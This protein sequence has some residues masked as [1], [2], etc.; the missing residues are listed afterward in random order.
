MA[1]C[2]HGEAWVRGRCDAMCLWDVA[3]AAIRPFCSEGS[4][5]EKGEW[6]G[7]WGVYGGGL[8]GGEGGSGEGVDPH[9]SRDWAIVVKVVESDAAFA[10]AAQSAPEDGP[11]AIEVLRHYAGVRDDNGD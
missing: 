1:I 7:I 9:L 3:S 6:D 5:R 10:G 4:S 11:Q 8:G 2:R